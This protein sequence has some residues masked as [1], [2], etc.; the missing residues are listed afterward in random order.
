MKGVK[1]AKRNRRHARIR[2]SVFGTATRPRL[3]VF[4]SARYMYA[5][6]IDDVKGVTL[7]AKTD[8]SKVAAK[9]KKEKAENKTDA[10][11]ALGV[12]LAKDAREKKITKAV[13]DRGGFKYHGRVKAFADAAREGGLEF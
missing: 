11:R 9:G 3:A 2:A 1:E 5:Q 13:F 7:V 10:A 6:L 4:R 12:A 8:R